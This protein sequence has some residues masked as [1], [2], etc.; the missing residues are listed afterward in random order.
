MSFDI[1]LQRLPHLWERS[2]ISQAIFAL[3]RIKLNSSRARLDMGWLQSPLGNFRNF[4][5]ILFMGVFLETLGRKFV[6]SCSCDLLP[7]LSAASGR[8]VPA[9]SDEVPTKGKERRLHWGESCYNHERKRERLEGAGTC[10][11]FERLHL[12]DSWP[13]CPADEPR[14]KLSFTCHISSWQHIA[15]C[16]CRACWTSE[17]WCDRRW[18]WASLGPFN[19]KLPSC[20]PSIDG[21]PLEFEILFSPW[22]LPGWLT[23]RTSIYLP[24]PVFCE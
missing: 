7:I 19:P 1:P 24:F 6:E 13:D 8:Y 5:K 4:S 18:T 15:S 2:A 21:L 23:V 3:T 16:P 17:L 12:S 14:T 20:S 9:L 22:K 11:C 10:H